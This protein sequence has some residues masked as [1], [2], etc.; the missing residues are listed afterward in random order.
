MDLNLIIMRNVAK[1]IINIS[2]DSN[3]TIS[4][5]TNEFYNIMRK[6]GIKQGTKNPF[7]PGII[8]DNY[9]WT[10]ARSLFLDQLSLAIKLEL[11]T[12]DIPEDLEC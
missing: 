10:M 11:L 4:D 5:Y 7:G 6:Y 1:D 2:L 8:H 9:E 12:N 3:K